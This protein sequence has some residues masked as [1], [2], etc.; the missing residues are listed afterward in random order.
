MLRTRPT[1]SMHKL[2]PYVLFSAVELLVS[3]R[4]NLLAPLRPGTPLALNMMARI[5][6]PWTAKLYRA[7]EP[8]RVV[9]RLAALVA[10]AEAD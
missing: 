4:L 9:I 6:V 2:R 3:L 1:L 5:A 10:A 8:G 7:S